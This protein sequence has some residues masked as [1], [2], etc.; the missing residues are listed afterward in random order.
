[1]VTKKQVDAVYDADLLRLL[2]NLGLKDAF[3]AE[4]L[5]CVFCGEIITWENFHSIFPYEND[6]K[7][8]CTRLKCVNRLISKFS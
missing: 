8:C 6:V 4:T 1:M 3:E 7:V 5:V 2:E